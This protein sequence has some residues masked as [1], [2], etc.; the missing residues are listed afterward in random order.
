MWVSLKLVHIVLWDHRTDRSLA[1]IIVYKKFKRW[2][3]FFLIF[4]DQITFVNL[5]I[6]DTCYFDTQLLKVQQNFWNIE[7]ILHSF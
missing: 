7:Y 2:K 3:A 5:C 6:K 1:P 4:F